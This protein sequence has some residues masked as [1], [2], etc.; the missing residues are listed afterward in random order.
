MVILKAHVFVE[1][2]VYI[3]GQQDQLAVIRETNNNSSVPYSM[4]ST[5]TA[6]S[7]GGGLCFRRR[8]TTVL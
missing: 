6:W 5:G 1:V 4:S 8:V 2:N 7:I 3:A